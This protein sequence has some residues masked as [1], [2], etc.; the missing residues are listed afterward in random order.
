MLKN[1]IFDWSGV[2]CDNIHNGYIV[3]MKIFEKYGALRISFHEFRKEW[4]QPY[5]IFYHKYL[6]HL[7]KRQQNEMYGKEII[8]FPTPK[9]FPGITEVLARL[10]ESG[11]NLVLLSSDPTVSL[12]SELKKHKLEGLFDGIYNDIHDKRSVI[13]KIINLWCFNSR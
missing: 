6:P 8:K 13:N 5:M 11:K 10:K 4:E 1:F 9:T 3:A 2:I 12:K 7:T